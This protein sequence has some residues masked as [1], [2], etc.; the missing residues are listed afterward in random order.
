MARPRVI[1]VPDPDQPPTSD[2]KPPGR[3]R[4]TQ[5]LELR[6]IPRRHERRDRLAVPRDD[7]GLPA[8]AGAQVV[9]EVRLGLRG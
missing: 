4:G 1:R 8:F 7:D 3:P 6:Q 5:P 9:A 2:A